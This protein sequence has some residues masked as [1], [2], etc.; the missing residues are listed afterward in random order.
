MVHNLP[1]PF[2]SLISTDPHH[3]TLARRS[4]L[5]ITTT[6]NHYGHR[7]A[8]SPRCHSHLSPHGLLAVAVFRETLYLTSPHSN[9]LFVASYLLN[10][11]SLS[12][13]KAARSRL[14][15]PALHVA[16]SGE[17]KRKKERKKER[18]EEREEISRDCSM[19]IR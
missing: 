14:R 18:S 5:P 15:L 2:P 3:L 13:P 6:L 19:C 7:L 11:H 12:F 4:Y 16:S 10:P 1:P 8:A 9:L 17:E